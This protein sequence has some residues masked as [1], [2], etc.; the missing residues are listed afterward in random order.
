MEPS[1]LERI[2]GLRYLPIVVQ[3]QLGVQEIY[4]SGFLSN[5]EYRY[6]HHTATIPFLIP[7]SF[8]IFYMY[9]FFILCILCE[10]FFLNPCSDSSKML[11]ISD[12]NVSSK[13]LTL[14]P[15]Y[16]K[17]LCTYSLC[18]LV[19]LHSF[20]SSHLFIIEYFFITCICTSHDY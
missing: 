10:S 8:N 4:H 11:S 5:F 3:F 16:L 15:P 20:G 18:S 2:R 9:S 12:Y 7:L 6:M 17:E 1:L 19:G 13:I 14:F